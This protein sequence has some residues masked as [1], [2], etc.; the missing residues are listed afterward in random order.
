MLDVVDF[1]GP[2]IHGYNYIL[3][4]TPYIVTYA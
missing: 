4:S 1:Q 3:R 2:Y